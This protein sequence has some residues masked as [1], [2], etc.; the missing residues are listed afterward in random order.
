MRFAVLRALAKRD[1]RRYFGNPIGYVFLTLFIFLSAA[2]A[3]WRPRFFLDNLATLDQL[4]EVFPYL[5]VGFVAALTMG[6]WAEERKQGTDELLL[7][8][9]VTASELVVGKYL[10]VLAVY[11]VSL[12]L[13]ASHVAVLVWLGSPDAGLMA[14]NY[15]GYWVAGAALIP[16]GMLASLLTANATVAFILAVLFCAAPVLVTDVGAAFGT[17][18]GQ[19]LAPLGL[20]AHF[21]DFAR[22][23]VSVSA[24][25]YFA[26]L[27]AV[28]LYVNAQLLDRQH[29]AVRGDAIPMP[30][31]IALRTAALAVACVAAIVLLG[32]WGI[33][34]DATAERLH[35]LGPDTRA[36]LDQLPA[37]RRV[38][39]Q[40]F[41]SPAVPAE[42]VQRKQDL[43]GT[44]RELTAASGGRLELLVQETEPY[45]DAARTARERFGI[46]PRLVSAP[47]SPSSE[48]QSVF[49]GAAFTSGA[50]EEVMPFL[51][52]GLSA[53]YE[54]ARSIRI[55][56]RT[57][58]KRIGIVDTDAKVFG[59]VDYESGRSRLPWAIVGE[60]RKQYEVVQITPA[61]TI[62]E[63]VDALLVVLPST[64]LQRE[65]D[66][67]WEAIGRGVPALILVDPV[68]AMDM[69]LAPAAPM[70][71]RLNPYADPSQALVRKNVGDVQKAMASIGV[72]WQP[73]RVAWDSYRPRSE[74]AQ[75]PREMVFVGAGNGNPQAFNP[76][77]PA[78]SGLQQ[79]LLMYPGFLT[80][81][82][83]KDVTFEPLIGTGPASGAT[84]YF[85]LVQPTP[86]GPVLNMKL[87]HEP[88]GRVQT[89]AAHVRAKG[90][91]NT[92]VI[93]DLDFV[94]DQFFAMRS[95]A[96][97][98]AGDLD[99][100][101]FFL[102]C[103]D[104]L[105]GDESFIALRNRRVRYRTLERVE[106][107][108]RAFVER[109]GREEQ[110]A[111]AEAEA[112]LAGARESLAR[113]VGAIEQRADLDGQAKQILA[114]NVQEIENRKL[115]VLQ[116][117]IEQAK[118]AKVH[119]SRERLESE[120]RRIQATIRTTA[121]ALPPLPVLIV[122]M[123][124][125]VR[126]RRRERES[127]ASAGRLREVP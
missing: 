95:E 103:I 48:M 17:A 32:R 53:E 91:V 107:A 19:R 65:M 112:A 78:T 38:L 12:L 87:A 70:A 15:A 108:T 104:V 81:A 106:A 79:L 86:A 13:S 115:Q 59:G 82:K 22:G 125:L 25:A 116:A 113:T 18:T 36:L 35:S 40:A 119:A 74:L 83:A 98:A 49:L 31:H 16:V 10:A 57:A 111:A 124:I 5:L 27:A 94:S 72:E 55:V 14:A 42:Y 6:V 122:G 33:R 67:T 68:P 47:D 121:V 69:R 23:I 43:V 2:G 51:E 93:A 75:M 77:H 21:A 89:L 45:S 46:V 54:I 50:D 105:A 60:L 114:R 92:I 62:D 9:P 85:Q 63:A 101:S 7:T 4:N 76:M 120:V 71:A 61:E 8:L 96:A 37:G 123:V 90:G 20:G 117:N 29:W 30:L 41:V 24:T 1:L 34:I 110:Q 52:H 97:G 88:E 102:N 84:G 44:L 64:L 39:I 109:R 100:V 66:H 73:A 127:A 56:T 11:S 126:R 58:R 118:N 28:F 26:A 3:F 99:N 80:D